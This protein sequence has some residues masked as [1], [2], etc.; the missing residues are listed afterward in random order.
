MSK[1]I[2]WNKNHHSGI[3]KVKHVATFPQAASISVRCVNLSFARR[4]FDGG[5]L[6]SFLADRR[7]FFVFVLNFSVVPQKHS[8]VTANF[9]HQLP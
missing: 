5:N 8:Q 3:E 2:I 4:H 7:L 6:L 9:G 1:Q